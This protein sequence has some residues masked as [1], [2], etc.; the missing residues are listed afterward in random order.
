MHPI[1]AAKTALK[2]MLAGRPAWANVDV[3]DSQ[4]TEFED[5]SRDAFWFE[6]TDLS[7]DSWA[8][9]GGQRRRVSFQ[10][11]FTIAVIREGDD[12]RATEDVVWSYLDDMM[13]A[14]KA[15]PSLSGAVQQIDD[16]SGQQQNEPYDR[17][18]RALFTGQLACVS[19]PY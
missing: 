18:W 10:L 11:G 4:P 9:I 2:T 6:P 17:M 13:V 12:D 3:H 14:I 16:L 1:P 15:N 8:W 5:F 7:A 19:K